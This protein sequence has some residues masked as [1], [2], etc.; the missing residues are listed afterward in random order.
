VL[1]IERQ[2]WNDGFG[3]LAGIDEA[4]RGPLA[5]PVV[6]AA[7]VLERDFAEREIGKS[8]QGLTDS[9]QLSESRR[10]HFFGVLKASPA[11]DVGVGLA[12]PREIDSINI[13]RATH[14]AMLRAVETL[15]TQPDF[16]LVDGLPVKGFPCRSAAIVGGDAKSISIA[17]A[18]VV[19]K[20]TRD[21]IMRDLDRQYP[22]YGFAGH[23]GY[24]SQA[25]VLALIEFGP[26]PAHRSSFRPVRE[27][28]DLHLRSS[29][30]SPERRLL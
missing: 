1:T 23:K 30:S 3:R 22:Q 24:G 17:A 26:C 11:V 6:A 18:S 4:G 19:A 16:I 29:G 10:D 12:G 9:K 5:G 21:S 2:F 14:M 13:L 15:K 28:A 25:H 27:A 20:V 7:V 8:L